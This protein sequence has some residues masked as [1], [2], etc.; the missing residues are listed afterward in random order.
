MKNFGINMIVMIAALA[1][2]VE[3]QRGGGA[4][5]AAAGAAGGPSGAGLS[6]KIKGQVIPMAA[7]MAN[8]QKID[9]L[10]SCALPNDLSMDEL[11]DAVKGLGHSVDWI[12][13]L[14][15]SSL[16]PAVA[17]L[18]AIKCT[19]DPIKDEFNAQSLSNSLM[20][21]KS[22]C[23]PP[24]KAAKIAVKGGFNNALCAYQVI[25]SSAKPSAIAK[26][27]GGQ[28]FD[29]AAFAAAAASAI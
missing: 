29:A 16:K 2:T 18:N 14:L 1:V 28:G 17:E 10:C 19:V 5:I 7:H 13:G 24:A 21:P 26:Q 22:G 27:A 9:S 8:Q 12:K 3:A 6:C 15:K 25:G 11:T 20:K 23:E 4:G